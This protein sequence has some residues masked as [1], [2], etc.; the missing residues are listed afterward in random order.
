M[1]VEAVAR[2]HDWNDIRFFLAV[3]R[4][5]SFNAAARDLG[6]SQPTV[7]RKIASLEAQFGAV[8]FDRHQDGLTLTQVGRSLWDE[9]L[10]IEEAAFAFERRLAAQTNEA[11]GLVRMSTTEGLG[12]LW[13]TPKLAEFS[14]RHPGLTL[15]MLL[16][17]HASDLLRREA[18]LA[19]R[20]TR[21]ITPDLIA[22]KVGELSFGLF[23]SREYI[24]RCGLPGSLQELGRH[25]LVS[26]ALRQSKLDETWQDILDAGSAVAYSTNS[27]LAE[28]AA[29]HSGLGVGLLPVYAARLFSLVRVLPVQ[30]WR[31]RDIWLVVHPDV[32]SSVRIRVL[33]DAVAQ[34]FKRYGHELQDVQDQDFS[35]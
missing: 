27:S 4:A 6:T 31:R 30:Q 20:L 26:L 28:I 14:Q 7:S 23:A 24:S 33:F 18:D 9:A 11:T 1:N 34:T 22:K 16:E 13:L 2:I 32:K 15:Q 19:L 29:V 8:L 25:R 10:G 35:I 21:P 12:T 3:G 5:G 17:N